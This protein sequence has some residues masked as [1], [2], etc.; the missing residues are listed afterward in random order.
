[1]KLLS[2]ESHKRIRDSFHKIETTISQRNTKSVFMDPDSIIILRTR[3]IIPKTGK[4]K[5]VGHIREYTY[6]EILLLLNEFNFKTVKL[7]FQ[8]AEDYRQRRVLLKIYNIF[9]YLVPHFA[10][11]I[12]LIATKT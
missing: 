2:Q 8:P 4:R 5:F 10:C 9:E 6:R 1:M 12:S 3:V 11:R 7:N